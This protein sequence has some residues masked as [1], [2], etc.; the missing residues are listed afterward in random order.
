VGEFFEQATIVVVPYT[1]ATQSGVVTIAATHQ[2]PVVG[3]RI[4]GLPEQIEDGKTG[5][6]VEPGSIHE[7]VQ[8]LGHL[9]DDPDYAAEL[10]KSLHGRY[11]TIYN[12]ETIASQYL[13]SCQK[14]ILARNS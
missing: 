11:S 12:W 9:L 3:T 14:A 5:L 4:G 6:L 1:E 2:L 10:S 13:D 7:L 8:A